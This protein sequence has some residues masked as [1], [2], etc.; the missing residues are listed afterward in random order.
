MVGG[1]SSHSRTLKSLKLVRAA[2]AA[3]KLARAAEMRGWVEVDMGMERGGGEVLEEA[4]VGFEK[5]HKRREEFKLRGP[6]TKPRKNGPTCPRGARIRVLRVGTPRAKTAV[7]C[8]LQCLYRHKKHKR[9]GKSGLHC[10]DLH[11]RK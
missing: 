7:A 3:V 9:I 5:D 8:R 6:A 4:V 11:K 10:L 1:G 2:A